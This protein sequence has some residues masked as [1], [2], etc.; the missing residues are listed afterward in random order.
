MRLF[1]AIET[2]AARP[3]WRLSTFDHGAARITTLTI[4]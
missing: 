4:R 1:G 3:L 2:S